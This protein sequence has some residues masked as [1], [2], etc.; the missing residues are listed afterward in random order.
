MTMQTITDPPELAD[1]YAFL[2]RKQRRAAPAGLVSVPAL[3]DAMRGDQR[4]ATEFLLRVGSGMLAFD[5][6]MGKTLCGLDWGRVIAKHTGKPVLMLA[7]PAVG[8]QHQR[9]GERFGIE[10][11]HVRGADQITGP[12]VWVTNYE[13]LHLFQH[14]DLGGLILDESSI[15]KSFTGATSRKLIEYG[16]G[17]PYRLAM[18]ATPA[19]NDHMELGQHSAFCGAMPSNEMLARWFTADQSQMGKYRLKRYGQDDFWS[20]MASWARMAARPSDLGF[21]DDGFDLP[22]LHMHLHPVSVDMTEGAEDGELIRRV[23]ISATSIHREKRRTAPLRAERIAE[24]VCA[25]PDEPW[26]I[27]CE[28]DYEADALRAVLPEAIEVRGSHSVDLKESR[29]DAFSR[30]DERLLITKPSVAGFGLNW[31]HCARCAFVGLSFSYE[32]YYQAVRRFWRFGQHRAVE[33][34]IALADTEAVIWQTIQRK[35]ADHARMKEQMTAAMRRAT[36]AHDTKLAYHPTQPVRLPN[37]L[38][39][40][41]A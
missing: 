9:E 32:S 16:Q 6:G 35:A 36:Q 14:L 31:Q 28:T 40:A 30:G 26:A 33:V 19:P 13:R 39:Q 7:P 5:T 25:E 3:N 12:G 38:K 15:L 21:P 41:A 11:K 27:W 17:V 37:W 24:L 18:T 20:W 10:A 8:P 29:L 23:D 22:Q 4:A 1:Y 34:H 2:R